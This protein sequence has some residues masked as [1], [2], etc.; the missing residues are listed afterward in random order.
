MCRA[1]PR[2]CLGLPS[3]GRGQPRPPTSPAVARPAVCRARPRCRLGR[4]SDGQPRA[5]AASAAAR[6][7]RPTG[8]LGRRLG[9]AARWAPWPSTR[10]VVLPGGSAIGQAGRVSGAALVADWLRCPA[11]PWV[12][13][14]LTRPVVPRV[15][16]PSTGPLFYGG[17]PSTKPVVPR[18]ALAPLPMRPVVPRHPRRQPGRPSRRRPPAADYAGRPAGGPRP[19]TTPVVPPASSGP[20]PP[21]SG[22]PSPSWALAASP[23]VGAPPAR[24]PSPASSR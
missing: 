8:S 17:P 22:T 24:R 18:A 7:G 2:C 10:P 20:P 16:L 12:P 3:S 14:P 6:A 15:A 11:A 1:R 4:W 19:L 5:G 23:C 21:G 13:W 9:R